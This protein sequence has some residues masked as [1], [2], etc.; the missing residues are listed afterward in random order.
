MQESSCSRQELSGDIHFA[1]VQQKK[2]VRALAHYKT[3]SQPWLPTAE[4]SPER[5][6]QGIAPHADTSD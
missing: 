3:T 5:P 4:M 2:V 6:T 1:V